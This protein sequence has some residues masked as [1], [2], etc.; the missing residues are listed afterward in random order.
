MKSWIFFEE[1]HYH[2]LYA[3]LHFPLAGI[4]LGK[5]TLTSILYTNITYSINQK[6]RKGNEDDFINAFKTKNP[7]FKRA[8]G[9]NFFHHENYRKLQKTA[10]IQGNEC[11][12]ALERRLRD[13]LTYEFTGMMRNH[14]MSKH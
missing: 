3:N 12:S 14:V 8:V 4:I 6:D 10:E 1:A 5:I 11:D 9:G 7:F 13:Y 2:K